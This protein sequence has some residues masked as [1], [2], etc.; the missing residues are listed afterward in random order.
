MESG[1]KFKHIKCKLWIHRT[2]HHREFGTNR[3]IDCCEKV[4][5]RRGYTFNNKT[6]RGEKICS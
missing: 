3:Q 4:L 1:V 2:G 5:N 6:R